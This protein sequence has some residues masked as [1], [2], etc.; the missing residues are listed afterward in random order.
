MEISYEMTLEDYVAFNMHYMRTSPASKRNI[1]KARIQGVVLILAAGGICGYLY[2]GYS[3]PLV[4]AFVVA[5]ALFAVLIPRTIARQ[6]KNNVKKALQKAGS[7]ACGPKTLSLEET[8]LRLCGGGEDSAYDYAAVQDI[9]EDTEH[10]YLFVGSM[11]ALIVPY[12]AFADAGARHAFL[13]A[14]KERIAEAQ[15][16]VAEAQQ[17]G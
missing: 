3:V 4:A 8:Q 17:K 10:Y 6:V 12:S 1:L 13:D 14:L 5:A 15:S 9:V 11:E 7:I 16:Q 2:G